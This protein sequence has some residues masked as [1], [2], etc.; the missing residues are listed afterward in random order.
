MDKRHGK[1]ELTINNIIYV[2]NFVN[3]KLEGNVE[4]FSGN[5]RTTVLYNNGVPVS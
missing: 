3:G 2:G 5:K 1:G 4:V